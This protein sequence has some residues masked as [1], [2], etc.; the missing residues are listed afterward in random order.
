MWPPVGKYP[1]D[2][3]SGRWSLRACTILPDKLLTTS[4]E[5]EDLPA[6]RASGPTTSSSSS[7]GVTCGDT[8]PGGRPSPAS[9]YATGRLRYPDRHEGRS[10]SQVRCPLNYVEVAHDTEMTMWDEWCT[11]RPER[12][13][14][15]CGPCR[16]IRPP[17]DIV[18]DVWLRWQTT[19]GVERPAAWLTT[20]TTRLSIQQLRSSRH[21]LETYPGTW[22]P[23]PLIRGPSPED[24]AEL[25]E[26]L[27]LGF[28][29]LLDELRPIERAVFVLADVFD[30]LPAEIASAVDRSEAACRQIASRARRRLH[31]D[32][33]HQQTAADRR[34]TDR[35]L[36]A[37]AAGDV[38]AVVAQ[39]APDVVMVH[40]G[41]PTRRAAR[42]PVIGPFRVAR[43]LVNLAQRFDRRATLTPITVNGAP[44]ALLYL[45]GVP[46]TAI[47]LETTGGLVTSIRM[48]RNP[49]KLRVTYRR[50]KCC[51]LGYSSVTRDSAN[52]Q[53]H[54]WRSQPP[55]EL[56]DPLLLHAHVIH[57]RR[58]HPPHRRPCR[59]EVTPPHL[60]PYS[61]TSAAKAQGRP[62][63]LTVAAHGETHQPSPGTTP[64]RRSGDTN[65]R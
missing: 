44:G 9:P 26:S 59:Q 65:G 40:D 55:G 17:E 62:R 48:I 64:R 8:V 24:T 47:S 32:R 6:R 5:S 3:S 63:G 22:L 14:S 12:R 23:E 15:P 45:S 36:A 58:Q 19:D 7:L 29:I 61:Q 2:S 39:L 27:T 25:T 53:H 52:R 42:Y 56:V 43:L 30:V 46:D 20:V 16:R 1:E 33:T 11:E 21:R 54:S 34:L 18:Q 51:E 41:G 37:V 10:L 57:R 49:D 60:T 38:D 50:H 31:R 35:F 4:A 28:L 13:T